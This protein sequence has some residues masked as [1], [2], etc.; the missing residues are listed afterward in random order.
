MQHNNFRHELLIVICCLTTLFA[1]L[2]WAEYPRISY[3]LHQWKISL[4]VY[5]WESDHSPL[6][7]LVTRMD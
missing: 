2:I 1:I 4:H 5:L 6:L 7:P 3:T